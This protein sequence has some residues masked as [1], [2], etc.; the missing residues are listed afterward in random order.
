MLLNKEADRTL[1]Q[2][3]FILY[4]NLLSVLILFDIGTFDELFVYMH[5]I[6]SAFRILRCENKSEISDWDYGRFYF[7][8]MEA[9]Q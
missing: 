6:G 3:S 2:S 5:M 7:S 8:G 9:Q 4:F 1:S